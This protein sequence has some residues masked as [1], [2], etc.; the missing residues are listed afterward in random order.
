V[1]VLFARAFELAETILARLDRL[2]ELLE[3]LE[4]K[5]RDAAAK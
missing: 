1:T 5:D 2:I 4:R 3:N